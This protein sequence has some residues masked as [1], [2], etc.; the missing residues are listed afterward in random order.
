L[1]GGHLDGRIEDASGVTRID[2][3]SKTRKTE[4]LELCARIGFTPPGAQ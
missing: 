2:Q 3:V 1:N 4:L